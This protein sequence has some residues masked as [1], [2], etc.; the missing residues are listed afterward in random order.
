MTNIFFIGD[1]HFGHK[2]IVHPYKPRFYFS[3]Y[4]EMEETLIENWN[5]IVSKNDEVWILGDICIT[6]KSLGV[7]K[8]L[9]GTHK[10]IL[11][12]HDTFRSRFYYEHFKFVS[13]A[14][15]MYIKGEKCILTHIPIHTEQLE[16]GSRYTM[17]V[18][19]HLHCYSYGDLRYFNVN[20]DQIN[21]TPIPI[22]VLE[23]R[24][25]ELT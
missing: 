21:L 18:H 19:G 5:S 1:P 9:N 24:V 7:L 22:E 20:A 11:G 14:Y 12:N 6:K 13:G 3:S 25:Q 4:T 8:K 23:K 17:N 16:E 10:A 15:K 2:E